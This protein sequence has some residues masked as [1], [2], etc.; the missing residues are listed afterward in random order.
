MWGNTRGRVWELVSPNSSDGGADRMALRPGC[1]S[2]VAVGVARMVGTVV[3][4]VIMV[5]IG[6]TPAA[7][8][9]TPA[10]GASAPAP[11]TATPSPAMAPPP[12][13]TAEDP[14]DDARH[15]DHL[16][17]AAAGQG[18][19]ER[20][21]ASREQGKCIEDHVR[22][23]TVRVRT[24]SVPI[25][26]STGLGGFPSRAEGSGLAPHV[27]ARGPRYL[28]GLREACVET[29][30]QGNSQRGVQAGTA[31]V[32]RFRDRRCR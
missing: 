7:T 14:I 18:D 3:V 17:Q 19:P 8:A 12:A 13:A 24:T 23:S 2:L 28:R 1:V 4:L 22:F 31:R 29:G 26:T 15:H 9:L 27:T 5:M 21:D 32:H 25:P 16:E 20:G 30:T 6:A 10:V 11:V